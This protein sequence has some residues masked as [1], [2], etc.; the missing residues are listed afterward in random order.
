MSA[1]T[2]QPATH[3]G[4]GEDDP[5]GAQATA[6]EVADRV[7]NTARQAGGHAQQKL[8]EQLDQRTSQAAARITE[9]ASDMRSVSEALREQGKGGPAKAAER[10]AGYAER[11]G[12][13]LRERD[14]D[15]L[16]ADAEDFGRRQP[17]AIATGGLA[18]GFAASRFLKA[19]SSRRYQNRSGGSQPE[20]LNR[21]S[22]PSAANGIAAGPLPTPAAG[23]TT[24]PRPAEP[25]GVPGERQPAS[26]TPSG[27]PGG[28]PPASRRPGEGPVV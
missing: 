23:A 12:D 24:S 3:A 7:Q 1:D 16:L 8:R 25:G 9:Q 28:T 15:Q 26:S 11:V 18:L 27:A 21:P 14:S 4:V 6:A 2:I 5:G 22:S 17:W 13:Y 20:H 19:S 10:M